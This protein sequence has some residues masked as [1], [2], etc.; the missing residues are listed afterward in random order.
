M[1]TINYRTVATFPLSGDVKYGG[2][3]VLITEDESGGFVRGLPHFTVCDHANG[4]SVVAGFETL[5]EAVQVCLA[6]NGWGT[7][8]IEDVT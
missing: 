4:F 5:A 3:S 6:N 2:Y 1:N 8:S 7:F